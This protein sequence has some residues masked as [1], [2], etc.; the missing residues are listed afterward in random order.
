LHIHHPFGKFY[1]DTQRRRDLWRWIDPLTMAIT[2]G[3]RYNPNTTVHVTLVLP[4][5]VVDQ[6]LVPL[7]RQIVGMFKGIQQPN[8]WVSI[9]G[10]PELQDP[11]V[12]QMRW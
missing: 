7:Y 4:K 11:A 5:P 6:T 9:V 2:D 3:C 12:A 8:L 10:V 1:S